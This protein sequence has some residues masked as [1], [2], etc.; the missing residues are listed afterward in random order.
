M[1]EKNNKENLNEQAP[2]AGKPKRKGLGC[3]VGV[4]AALAAVIVLF[5]LAGNAL[6]EHSYNKAV[7]LWNEG[8]YPDAVSRFLRHEDRHD[9]K[10]YI[11]EFQDMMTQTLTG[12][13]WCSED[14]QHVLDHGGW[15]Y[16][17]YADG[18]CLREYIAKYSTDE[19]YAV[20]KTQELHWT[21]VEDGVTMIRVYYSDPDEGLDYTFSYSEDENGE[22]K[23]VG[24]KGPVVFFEE[25]DVYFYGWNEEDLLIH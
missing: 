12:V 22:F 16:R 19:H 10:E 23:V 20:E 21:L 25:Y 1:D 15:R 13:V 6:G 4:I 8:K 3:V 11:A 17:F 5:V 9:A 24:L 7:E 18:T 14:V 2:P